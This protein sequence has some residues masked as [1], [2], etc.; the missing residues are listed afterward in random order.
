MG[1]NLQD[2]CGMRT[3]TGLLL[4][5]LAV[6]SILMACGSE[7]VHDADISV[8]RSTERLGRDTLE[9]DSLLNE[10]IR[11]QMAGRQEE[12]RMLLFRAMRVGEASMS[13]FRKPEAEEIEGRLMNVYSLLATSYLASSEQD[14]AIHVARAGARLAEAARDSSRLNRFY[15]NIARCY[16]QLND[17]GSALEWL[18]RSQRL[19]GG[20][21]GGD[22]GELHVNL[23]NVLRRLGR[24]A[25]AMERVRMAQG[26]WSAMRA[27][28]RF[29]LYSVLLFEY[30]RTGELDSLEWC[31]RLMRDLERAHPEFTRRTR[32]PIFEGELRLRRGDPR[33]ALG[34]LVAADSLLSGRSNY[35]MVEHGKR[36]LSLAYAGNGMFE[37]AYR[38]AEEAREV[39]LEGMHSDRVR[40][41]AVEQAEMLHARERELAA[42]ELLARER[43]RQLAWAIVVASIV[44]V[45]L[46]GWAL[47][48]N[49]RHAR[50][51]AKANDE[52]WSAQAGLMKAERERAAAEVRTNIARDVHDDLGSELA[53]VALLTEEAR[54]S[55]NDPAAHAEALSSLSDHAR[56]VGAAVREI[57]WSTDPGSDNVGAM[58]D[59]LD[60]T[61]RAMVKG[62]NVLMELHVDADD[63]ARALRPEERRHVLLVVKEAVHNAIKHGRPGAIDVFVE[64]KGDRFALRVVDD[65]GAGAATS[66]TGHGVKNMRAR[67]EL[68]QGELT[69]MPGEKGGTVV[70]AHGLFAPV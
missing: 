36:S 61:L 60:H 65:G 70:K 15:L 45:A 67:M 53:K 1:R 19:A 31:V 16:S 14:S 66:G 6:W 33:S 34:L 13:Y 17:D 51:L 21:E 50:H 10:A 39:L 41:M 56:K 20:L 12:N 48:R 46:L 4:W 23:A 8:L 28:S 62:T 38:S 22:L 40:R 2:I 37:E 68:L 25:E 3:G 49:R 42:A 24:H 59:H 9:L 27:K 64:V 26:H 7:R 29:D 58:I 43:S 18:E 11:H 30:S 69:L 44:F 5:V 63:R 35:E 57:I 54:T 52:L 55:S 47:V 32:A